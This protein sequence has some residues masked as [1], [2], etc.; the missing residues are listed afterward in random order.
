MAPFPDNRKCERDRGYREKE[1]DEVAFEPILGLSA[2]EHHF[3][4]RERHGHRKNSPSVNLQP[5]VL[6]RRLDLTR[7][8]R[9]IRQQAASQQQ[10]N[11][12]DRNVDEEHPPPAPMIRNPTA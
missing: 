5:P 3:Q 12:A 10:R 1:N 6:A 11:D 2:I 8:L 9:R 4:A 7:E